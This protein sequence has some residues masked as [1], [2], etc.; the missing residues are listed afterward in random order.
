[1][2][3]GPTNVCFFALRDPVKTFFQQYGWHQLSS[4]FVG[5]ALLGAGLSTIFFPI[6]G[7]YLY[8]VEFLNTSSGE[9]S[10]AESAWW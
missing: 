4:D 7:R 2:R 10:H 9:K 5:G 1:M 8:I 6:N 3:N